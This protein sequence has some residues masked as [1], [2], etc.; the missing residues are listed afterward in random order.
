VLARRG[1]AQR[2]I[3]LL[4]A[5]LREI[6]APSGAGW[7]VLALSGD[8]QHLAAAGD[9]RLIRVYR[10]SD[11]AAVAR[12][13]GHEDVVEALAL[14]SDGKTVI[15]GGRDRTVRL[16]DLTGGSAWLTLNVPEGWVTDVQLTADQK[17]FAVRSE[18]D[19]VR[20]WRLPQREQLPQDLSAELKRRFMLQLDE[21]D[22]VRTVAPGQSSVEAA[23]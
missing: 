13:A 7:R 22:Q 14:T 3:V 21:R 11:G 12:F 6:A 17:R 20:V 1:G 8:G 16:W 9:D 23:P 10:T 18:Q 2:V 4:E 19:V 15:S 5:G